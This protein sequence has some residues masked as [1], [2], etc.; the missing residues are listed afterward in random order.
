MINPDRIKE[1]EE[2]YFPPD[3]EEGYAL[4]ELL[5]ERQQLV[6][7]AEAAERYMK[8]NMNDLLLYAGKV[9]EAL[10]LWKSNAAGNKLQ[11]GE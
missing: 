3:C 6:A 7:I 4:E 5:A 2:K 10:A 9:D 8:C 1:I 11:E